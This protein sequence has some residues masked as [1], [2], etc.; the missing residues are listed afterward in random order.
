MHIDLAYYPEIIPLTRFIDPNTRKRYYNSPTGPL[1]S[2]TTILSAT[3]PESKRQGLEQWRAFVGEEKANS[4]TK[5]S[6]DIGTLAHTHVQS[7]LIGMEGV[8]GNHPM[9]VLARDIGE[10]HYN[11]HWMPNVTEIR[12]IESDLYYEGLY[13]GACDAIGI[14]QDE[15][16]IIDIK[17]SRKTRTDDHVQDYFLQIA[18]YALAFESLTG[19]PIEHG[20]IALTTHQC[21]NQTWLINPQDMIEYKKL[22][23]E[24]LE[25]YY[26]L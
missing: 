2:V 20:V 5:Y 18:A 25:A 22:W 24:R 3:M 21:T 7:R 14:Y 1:P 19:T 4:I 8:L 15:L 13:A 26:S 6:T 11:H 9:R 16:C 12:G 10:S 23:I 17:T